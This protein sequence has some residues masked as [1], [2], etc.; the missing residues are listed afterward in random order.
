ME[1]R[2]NR[3]ACHFRG[4]EKCGG[5]LFARGVIEDGE[6]VTTL[7][8]MDTDVKRGNRFNWGV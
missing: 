5:E 7:R 3:K 6:R 2:G 4:G 1:A 8:K